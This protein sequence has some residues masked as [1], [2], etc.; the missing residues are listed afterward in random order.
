[1]LSIKKNETLAELE[2][3]KFNNFAF[4]KSRKIDTK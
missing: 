4:Q 3:K 1:M 2:Y